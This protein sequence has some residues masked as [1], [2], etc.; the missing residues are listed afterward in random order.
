MIKK[1]IKSFFALLFLFAIYSNAEIIISKSG[2][3]IH[4]GWDTDHE[5]ILSYIDRKDQNILKFAEIAYDRGQKYRDY[6]VMK[7]REYDLPDEIFALAAIESSYLTNARSSAGAIGM[8]QFMRP[9]ARE[10]GLVS[11][12]KDHRTDWKK[13]TDAAMRYI[14]HLKDDH[15]YGDL[16]LTIL[17]YNA[18][19]G[20]VKRAIEKNQTADVWELIKDKKTFRQ[21]S[22]DYLPKFMLYQNFFDI[23]DQIDNYKQ[24]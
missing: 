20:K 11:G 14:K 5:I 23:L 21:E 4:Y 1:Y 12:N 7:A 16:E 9:T 10:F 3:K 19:L 18:G 15:F 6:I 17:A 8:W 22:I 13:S 2:G 24:I